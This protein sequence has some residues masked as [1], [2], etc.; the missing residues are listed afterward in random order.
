M[1][2]LQ[3]FQSAQT[4]IEKSSGGV[5]LDLHV[6]QKFYLPLI[7]FYIKEREKNGTYIIGVQGSQGVGKTTLNHLIVGTLNSLGYKAMGFSIDDFYLS[8]ADRKELAKQHSGNPFYL[9]R[10]M[11]GTHY[12][13][14]LIRALKKAKKGSS[15]EIPVFDKSLHQG[16]GDVTEEVIHVKEKVDFVI[17]EGWCVNLPLAQASEFPKIMLRNDYVNTLFQGFDPENKHFPTVLEYLESYREIWQLI[18]NNTC[19]LGG[20][21]RWIEGWR[22]D[23]EERLIALKG[24]GMTPDEVRQFVAPYIPFT[25]LYFDPETRSNMQID[26]LLNIM[27]NHQPENL[28]FNA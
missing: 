3:A 9:K 20:D 4:E 13:G 21:I 12:H 17:L 11:P 23:Q 2:L 18:D 19:M 15:F 14:K 25:W 26:C 6:V 1:N 16:E 22:K 8:Y 5:S 28:S 7:E 10:G 27:Q 24:T